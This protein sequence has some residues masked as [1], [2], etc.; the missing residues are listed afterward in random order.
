MSIAEMDRRQVVD[1]PVH[2]VILSCYQFLYAIILA[3]AFICSQYMVFDSY[4]IQF[5]VLTGVLTSYNL[6]ELFLLYRQS[7]ERFWMKPAVLGVFV[8]FFLQ[9]GGLTNYFYRADNGQFFVNYN[10]T[11]IHEPQWLAMTMAIVLAASV[12]FWIGYR[13]KAG[14]ELATKYLTIYGRMWN[15]PV[16]HFKLFIGLMAGWII[17]LLLNYYGGIGHRFGELTKE[18]GSMPE[19]VYRLKIFEDVSLVFM[20]IFMYLMYK[21]KGVKFYRNIFLFSLA[22]ESLFALTSGARSTII[23]VFIGV[24]L[25]DYYFKERIRIVWIL[26]GAALLFFAMTTLDRFK[27]FALNPQSNSV[28]IKD[29]I[30]YIRLANQYSLLQAQRAKSD[31]DYQ[32][33]LYLGAVGRFNYINE[34]THVI[35]Y[36]KTQGLDDDDPDFITPM[37]TFPIFAIF[38]KYY[39]F[40]EES[41]N[42][43]TWATELIV[44]HHRYSTAISPVGF[45]YAAGGTMFVLL[46]FFGLG[47][48]M[49]FCDVLLKNV[50][51]VIAFILFLAILKQLVMF[52]SV[53]SGSLLNLVRYGLL[54]P[55]VLWILFRK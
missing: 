23:F 52:D 40:G 37:F 48:L 39:L 51:T 20:I 2:L 13:L 7:P 44:G 30:E 12:T 6:L 46:V 32:K 43:G 28:E 36:K 26:G 45:A 29:P 49:K 35:R 31:R 21:H 50:K 18:L 53:V 19:F 4:H 5:W 38:P 15:Y 8:I 14:R 41:D 16:S 1:I 42:F 22:F 3:F 54:L 27:S 11:F 25:V 24:F 47:I 10:R 17:K 33:T 55:P 34:A 9:L